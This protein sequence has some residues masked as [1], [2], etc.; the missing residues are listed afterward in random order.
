MRARP[1][2]RRRTS[3]THPR[4][5]AQL[6]ANTKANQVGK[7]HDYP[8]LLI[9]GLDPAKS[10]ALLNDLAGRVYD[11][12]ERLHHGQRISDLIAG[13]DAVI[14]GGDATPELHPGTAHGQYWRDRVRL[15]Q[16]VWPDPQG[17]FPWDSG[18]AYPQGLQPIIGR[19]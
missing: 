3:R 5:Y 4:P 14:V 19:L 7:A 8:K 6:R 1:A 2:S 9:A 16:I 18:Y 11:R 10:K 13:Y 17:R 12:A 15:Q